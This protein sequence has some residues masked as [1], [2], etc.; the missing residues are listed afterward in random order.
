M[1]VSSAGEYT[2][3]N[4]SR[5][6]L[7]PRD[8]SLWRWRGTRRASKRV[9]DH[10]LRL[11]IVLCGR[12]SGN[13]GIAAAPPFRTPGKADSRAGYPV[14]MVPTVTGYRGTRTRSAVSQA[15]ETPIL[16][17]G[18]KPCDHL[19]HAFSRFPASLASALL[20]PSRFL[21]LPRLS[22]VAAP[23]KG[24]PHWQWF[25]RHFPIPGRLPCGR[26]SP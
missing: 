5:S 2:K 18:A 24:L 7:R 25:P 21:L 19:P 3:L 20:I 6:R 22:A 14:A 1:W 16:G 17:E 8:H 15:P 4:W 23:L 26:F 12:N 13:S 9:T 10:S 11:V